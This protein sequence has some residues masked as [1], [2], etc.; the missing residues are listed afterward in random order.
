[1]AFD[2]APVVPERDRKRIVRLV[3]FSFWLLIFE[4]S[5]RKWVAPQYSQY[6]YFVRD[7]FALWIYAIALRAGVFRQQSL[8][9]Y[10]GMAMAALVAVMCVPLVLT[11]GGQYTPILALYGLRNY[12]LYIPMAFVI[13]RCFE[14]DD[15]RLLAHQCML[16]ILVAAPLAVLQFNAPANHPL[17]VGIAVTVISS[18]PISLREA[19]RCVPRAPSLPRSAC[20]ISYRSA[21]PS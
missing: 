4:G 11:S 10:F 13:G 12:F 6:L 5:L 16:A 18:S 21:S 14:F 15:I 19:A 8:L 17:N 2:T 9:L 1:M 20:P 3:V 7:P